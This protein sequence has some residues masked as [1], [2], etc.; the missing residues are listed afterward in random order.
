M[1][2]QLDQTQ[3]W[4]LQ[5]GRFSIDSSNLHESDPPKYVALDV[6]KPRGPSDEETKAAGLSVLSVDMRATENKKD[7]NTDKYKCSTLIVRRNKEFTI[8]I[9]LDRAFN[10]EQDDVQL[11]FLIGSSPNEKKGTYITVSIG[12]RKHKGHWKGRVVEI[13][14]NDVTVGITPDTG[15]IIGRFRTYVALITDLGKQHT[16]RNPDTD[17]YVLF[18]PWDPADQVYVDK[19]EDRQEYVMNDVGIIYNGEF[20][21]I[22]YRSWNFGQFEEGVLDACL[23]LMDAGK[24]PLMFRGNATEVVRQGS[25]LLNAQDDDGLLVG[26]WSGDYSSGTAPTAWTGSPEILLKYV[27]EGCEPVCF[28]QCW[29]F[30]GVLNTLM[31]CLGIPSRII[32]NF[33]SAHDNTGN[34]K[35]DIVLDDDGKV[36]R[37]Q[38]KDSIWNYHCWNEVYMKRLDLPE[39]YSGWQVVDSTPQETS[40][41]LHR[42]GPTSVSAIKEG[43]LSFPFDAKFVFAEVNSDVVYHKSDKYG[44]MSIIYVDSSYMGKALVTKKKGSI[45]Y[46]DITSTYKY[47]EG[48]LKE[49]ETMQMAVSRGVP[50]KDYLPLTEAGVDF[51][52]QADTI[53]MGDNLKLTLNIKNHTSQTCTLSAIIT[54]CVVYYTGVTSTAF[55][56]ENMS[57]TVEASKT[58]SLTI[59]VK[60]LEY[61]PHL[62][63][64]SNL[65]FMVYGHVE[66]NDA[67]ISTMRVVT[68]SPPE[69]AIKMTA[70]PRVGKE[71]IVSVD[72]QNPYDFILKNVQLRID[73][74]GLI[75]TKLKHYSRILPGASV[76]YKV[77]FFPLSLGKKV[78][79][80]CLD[81]PLLR[82]VTNQIEFEVV[83]D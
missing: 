73:G 75:P 54:G 47:P 53:K 26:N 14:G 42:C 8:I 70:S 49:R 58:E 66:E 10:A 52:L 76:K 51:E 67:S 35:T 38:T 36:D 28:A 2:L 55:K 46:E 61:M 71:V 7:H 11:E 45:K 6:P 19:E 39:K 79:M 31:R 44:K 15:C 1:S 17:F 50:T 22:S 82:Q 78:L 18:N 5:R 62:V 37:S 20:N 32:T 16:Q 24:V 63:E 57:T 81:C 48:S 12:K 30:A 27:K 41:G 25:A 23:M 68:L 3:P 13:Q 74:P 33:L 56:H 4:E 29:V 77:S 40:D 65:L 69:L 80:A 21:N 34:L 83:Q 59:D 72:F 64:Q 43:E 9:K 60:A